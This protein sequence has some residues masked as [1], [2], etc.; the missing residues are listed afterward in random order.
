[1]KK[2]SIILLFTVFTAS[3]Q[4]YGK[5]QIVADLP[6][7]VKEVSGIEKFPENDFLWAINDSRNP[8]EVYGYNLGTNTFE[9]TLRVKNATNIDWEDL[10]KGPDGTLYIGDFGNNR[11]SRT[12]LTI[13]SIPQ[14]HSLE[15]RRVEA[16]VTT[17]RF[18]DQEK[19]PPKDKSLSFDVEAFIFLKGNFYLFTRNRAK[20]YDGTTKIYKLPAREGDFVATLIGSFET[21][22]DQSDCEIT[23]A[24][25]HEPSGKIA[26]L[27][28]NKVWIF[29]DYEGDAFLS[30]KVEKI[31]LHHTSQ[32]ESIC[33]V[34]ENKLLIADE[35]SRG[36]G[37]NLYLLELEE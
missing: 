31:K 18:E 33:F 14:L 6:G 17:F 22:N 36:E 29:C 23:G 37:G 21:C 9:I 5:L 30:G 32:K 11:S 25:I 1:M 8:P 16:G 19:F 2:I 15:K 34:S 10:T 7:L 26:L 4:D 20:K 28:Y 24:A 12:D 3:C 13:Y 35:R 27:S